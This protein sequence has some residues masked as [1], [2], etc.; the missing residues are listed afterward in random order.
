MYNIAIDGPSGVGK[1]TLAK[2]LAKRLNITYL[3]T[4]AMYRAMAW[5]ALSLGIDPSDEMAVSAFVDDVVIDVRYKDGVQQIFVDGTDVSVAIREHHMSKASSQVSKHPIVRAK[6]V[7]MQREIASRQSVVLDGRDITSVVLPDA[8]YKFFLTAKAEVRAK[9]RV[10][11]LEAKGDKVDF[12]KILKDIEERDYNDSH[13]AISP[14]VF[15]QDSVLVDSSDMNAEEVL[16][17]ILSFI[18]EE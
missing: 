4:G 10:K 15:T 16:D 7:A 18:K 17:Y 14:L 2:A 9:R 8:K 12:A 5:K 6:L 13:R 1:S 3:D 11:E